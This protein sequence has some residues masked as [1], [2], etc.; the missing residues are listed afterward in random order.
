MKSSFSNFA[1]FA[2]NKLNEH[3][4]TTLRKVFI[5]SYNNNTVSYKYWHIMIKT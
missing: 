5:T 2:F 4:F 1:N 3:R